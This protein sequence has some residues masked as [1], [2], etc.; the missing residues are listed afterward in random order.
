MSECIKRRTKSE[1]TGNQAPD[2]WRARQRNA[3]KKQGS[4]QKNVLQKYKQ[5]DSEIGEYRRQDLESRK[6]LATKKSVDDLSQSNRY[7]PKKAV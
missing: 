6:A 4:Y 2:K 5:I 3:N 7:P 1:Q